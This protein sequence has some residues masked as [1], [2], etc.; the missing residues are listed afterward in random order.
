[1]TSVLVSE[2][3]DF[4]EISRTVTNVKEKNNEEYRTS[5][6]DDDS[7][8]IYS[9]YKNIKVSGEI[10]VK[11]DVMISDCDNILKKAA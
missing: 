1:M 3:K 5:V 11:V 7:S 9:T 6:K 10:V 4:G 2:T 8:D